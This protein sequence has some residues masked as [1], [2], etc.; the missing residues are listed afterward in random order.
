MIQSLQSLLQI[1]FQRLF[2]HIL[3]TANLAAL[4]SAF[5]VDYKVP[6]IKTGS[7]NSYFGFSVSQHYI[8]DTGQYVYVLHIL[9]N[10]PFI[11]IMYRLV[12]IYIMYRL[13]V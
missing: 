10:C 8:N 6:L 11:Y 5:N 7:D 13:V 9:L 1:S 2:I 12:V 3:I 4:P